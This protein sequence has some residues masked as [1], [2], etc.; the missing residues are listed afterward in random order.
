V[1]SRMWSRRSS[2]CKGVRGGVRAVCRVESETGGGTTG[3][4]GRE[5]GI[6]GP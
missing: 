5:L 3:G 4:S 1:Q 6:F 2:T